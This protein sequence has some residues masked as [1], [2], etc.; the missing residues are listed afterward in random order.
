MPEPIQTTAAGVSLV[1]L[2]VTFFGPQVGPYVVIIFGGVGGG[3]WALSSAAPLTR[4]AGSWLML[5]CV[6]TSVLLTALVAGW[7]GPLLGVPVTEFYSLVSLSI[8]ALGNKWLDIIE[9]LKIRVQGAISTG[10]KP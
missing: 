1:T 6:V 3:L 9:S 10:G 7:I 5:R 2:A 8:A 4:M